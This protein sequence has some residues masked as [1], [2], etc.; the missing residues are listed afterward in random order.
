MKVESELDVMDESGRGMNW[1][2]LTLGRDI[3]I[4]KGTKLGNLK[5]TRTEQVKSCIVAQGV[6]RRIPSNR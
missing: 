6:T 3:N 2:W 4:N 5:T 1:R